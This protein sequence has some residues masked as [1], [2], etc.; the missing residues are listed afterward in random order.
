[1]ANGLSMKVL[2]QL[3]KEQFDKGIASVKNSISGL[4][5]TIKSV[6]GMIMGGMGLGYLVSQFKN[7]A[8]QLSVVKATM[9][10]V[11]NGFKEY[12]ENMEFMQRQNSPTSGLSR[13]R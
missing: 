11:S 8:T 7:T 13:R 6:A 10:N 2:L 4:G 3:Q 5:K 9:E 12:S 1:M